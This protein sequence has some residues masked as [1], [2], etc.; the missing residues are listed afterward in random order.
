[1]AH[2]VNTFQLIG[3]SYLARKGAWITVNWMNPTIL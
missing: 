1:M 2:S 3:N